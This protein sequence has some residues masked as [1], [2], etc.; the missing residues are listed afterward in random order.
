[1]IQSSRWGGDENRGNGFGG[2]VSFYHQ[3]S[4]RPHSLKSPEGARNSIGLL[5]EKGAVTAQ[6]QD[7]SSSGDWRGTATGK[8]QTCR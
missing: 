4:G 7:R 8:S 3:G 2:G 1:M 6:Q 5:D